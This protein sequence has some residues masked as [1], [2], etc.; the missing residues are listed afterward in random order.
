MKTHRRSVD[1]GPDGHL[2][3]AI[4][5]D[6]RWLPTT[7]GGCMPTLPH[8]LV[9]RGHDDAMHPLPHLLPLPTLLRFIR[10]TQS[11]EPRRAIAAEQ[12]TAAQLL[13]QPAI[14]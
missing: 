5:A 11:Q 13:C 3:Q 14:A 12:A 7:G 9:Y 8:S 1:G 10:A 4:V 6:R 2:R